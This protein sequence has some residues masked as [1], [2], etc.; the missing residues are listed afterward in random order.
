MDLLRFLLIAPLALL[1]VS[2]SSSLPPSGFLGKDDAHLSE[3]PRL[4]FSRSWKNPDVDLSQYSRVAVASVRKDRLRSLGRGLAA[5]S[6]R[7]IGDTAQKDADKMAAFATNEFQKQ[8]DK[9]EGIS[10]SLKSNRVGSAN[11][12]GLAILETNLVELVPGK[13]AAQVLK[14][15]FPFAGFL[16]RPS[17]GIEGRLVDARTGQTLFAF[18][19]LEKSEISYLDLQKFTYYGV[20]RREVGRW[21][22]QLREVVESNGDR[23][24]QDAFPIQPI[25]W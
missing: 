13:P 23:M 8:I 22:S 16:N 4:P 7:N 17:I 1:F 15:F 14:V 10:A 25:T 12:K 18:S 5:T 24:I 3:N 9:S 20:Q 6:E 2:C 21:G 11:S 19:D